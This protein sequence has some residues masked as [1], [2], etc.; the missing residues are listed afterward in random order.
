MTKH[1]VFSGPE[2]EL[3]RALADA[4]AGGQVLMTRP[5]WVAMRRKLSASDD[6]LVEHLGH[7]RL[8]SQREVSVYQL[9]PGMASPMPKRQFGPEALRNVTY[10]KVRTTSLPLPPCLPALSRLACFPA[11]SCGEMEVG[12]TWVEKP[13]C[14][15]AVWLVHVLSNKTRW[16]SC[17]DEHR[18]RTCG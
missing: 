13:T 6:P 1:V 3:A 11:V 7:Y 14:P 10:L 15:S 18:R 17:V 8:Q 12:E 2:V 9:H 4:A 16:V 5:T